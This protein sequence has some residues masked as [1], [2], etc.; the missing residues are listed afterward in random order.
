MANTQ[1]HKPLTAIPSRTAGRLLPVPRLS[2][3]ITVVIIALL[4]YAFFSRITLQFYA[5]VLFL[6][7]SMTKSMWVSVVL[8]GV[9][10]T[11][12]MIPFRIT[13]LLKSANI[14][15]FKER[16]KEIEQSHEQQFV[17]RKSVSGGKRVALY[18][19]VNF[20]VYLT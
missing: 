8:L 7:Y 16:F 13:N 1:P 17:L 19:L 6:F 12:L 9:F 14:K 10:Q 20:F 4:I 5:S 11:L 2:T 18:Y 3:I 15:E